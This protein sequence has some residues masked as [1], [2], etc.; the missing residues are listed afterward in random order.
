MIRGFIGSTFCSLLLVISAQ[1]LAADNL[2]FNELTNDGVTIAGS[3]VKLPPPIMADGLDAAAQAKV[4]ESIATASK[5]VAELT[6]KS[7]VAPFVLKI[8]ETAGTL[9]RVDAYFIVYGELDRLMQDG[10][11]KLD[12]DPKGKAPEKEPALRSSGDLLDEK[13]LAARGL[14]VADDHEN[15]A[16]S[17][18]P[19]FDRLRLHVTVRSID[20][21][22][23]DSVLLAAKIDERFNKDEKYDNFWQSLTRDDAG[24]L[25]IEDTKHP[26][27]AA[28]SYAKATQLLEPKGAIFVEYH[29]AFEE[30]QGWF[31]GAK[32]LTSKLP[33]AAQSNIRKL[34]QQLEKE[35]K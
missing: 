32:L 19:I 22:G 33:L 17:N 31:N 34:R 4:L 16:T 21:R 6:R 3:K 25:K 28:V 12:D 13:T 2:I 24:D 5:P 27:A 26:Y 20:S 15:I 14:K 18:F 1:A 8:D 7:V 35:A 9:K 23:Q 30:P 29:L 10:F 11:K